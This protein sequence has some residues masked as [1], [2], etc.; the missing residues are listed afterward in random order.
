MMIWT[1]E[2]INGE[3]KTIWPSRFLDDEDDSA[4]GYLL[5]FK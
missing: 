1:T 3:T 4:N 5:Y 2:T